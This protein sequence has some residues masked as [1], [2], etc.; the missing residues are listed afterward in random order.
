MDKASNPIEVINSMLERMLGEPIEFRKKLTVV[1][2]DRGRVYTTIN[3][4]PASNEICINFTTSA[5]PFGT[6]TLDNATGV[7]IIGNDMDAVRGLGRALI[8]VADEI[9]AE[10][11]E[12]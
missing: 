7:V 3:S 5:E 4:D 10:R 1:Y 2:P 9:D 6:L 8:T 12:D 11:M